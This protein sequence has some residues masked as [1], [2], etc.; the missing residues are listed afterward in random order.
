MASIR[1]E[2]VEKKFGPTTVIPALDL[3]IAD[4]EFLVLVGPSGCGKSTLLR[5]IAGLE[6]ISSGKLFID[7]QLVN[8]LAPKDRDIAIVFQNY[9]LYPHMTAYE[10]MAFGLKVRGTDKKT[11]QEKVMAAAKML[12]IEALLQRKPAAMSGGQLQRVAI[13]R[14]MVRNPRVFLFDEPLSNL[15]AKLRGQMRLEIA[16][17]HQRLQTTIV[18]VTHDQVEAMT[19]GNRIAVMNQGRIQQIDTPEEVYLNPANRFVAE[20]IGSPPINIL[21]GTIRFD[22]N[23]LSL[24]LPAVSIPLPASVNRMLKPYVHKQ[25]CMGIRP[26]HLKLVS[27]GQPDEMRFDTSVRLIE[28]LGHEQLIHGMLGDIPMRAILSVSGQKM[29]AAHLSWYAAPENTLFFDTQSGLRIT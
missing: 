3:A 14:A 10:N 8:N 2:K 22:N 13:G 12:D 17:L 11:I 23:L 16:G 1:F 29:K 26:E 4:R 24:A 18:Y 27:G 9:A 5:L 15:D 19:L 7:E 20:F 6:E 28:L 21:T 25:V